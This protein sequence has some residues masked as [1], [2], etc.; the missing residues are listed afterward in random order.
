M[1]G[2]RNTRSKT[3][4]RLFMLAT[5]VFFIVAAVQF[6]IIPVQKSKGVEQELIE[7]YGYANKYSP[8]GNGLIPA[9]RIE[10][11]IGVRKAV[12]NNCS[13]YHRILDDVIKL[14]AIEADKN[15]PASQKASEGFNSFR[16]MFNAA[17]AFLEFMD[18]RNN[19]LLAAEMGLG[20][21]MYIYLAAYGP[22]LAAE[23]TSKYAEQEDAFISARTRSEYASILANQL[24]ALKIS[25]DSPPGDL[26][27][28]LEKE[29]NTLRDA[30]DSSPWAHGPP[31]GTN[32]S[33]APYRGQLDKL[34]CQGI[35]K[36]ELLQKNR[37]LNLEG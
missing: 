21:Y 31:A 11:F 20:E 7:K 19:A 18:A 12:Q 26:A 30:P 34:Y 2:N 17:P 13:I 23:S 4:W 35:V 10:R 37:G 36:I 24:D 5:V 25:G 29:I 14:E 28:S 33:L 16:S 9:E 22:Q 8:P 27:A 6:I 32:E 15:M 3:R 1:P